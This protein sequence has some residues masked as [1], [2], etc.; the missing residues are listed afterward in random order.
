MPP[1][2]PAQSS[3]DRAKAEAVVRQLWIAYNN[4]GLYGDAHPLTKRAVN[5]CLEALN[6]ALE[7]I[8]MVTLHLEQDFIAC[9]EWRIEKR[10]YGPRL[11]ARLKDAKIQSLSF[12]RDLDPVDFIALLEVLSNG[13]DYPLVDDLVDELAERKAKGFRFNYVTYQKVTM[14]ESIIQR[15]LHRFAEL[16]S[17]NAG[18]AESPAADMLGAPAHVGRQSPSLILS[19]L[20]AIRR[21]VDQESGGQLPPAEEIVNSLTALRTSVIQD[22]RNQAAN[23]VT[24]EVDEEVFSEIEQLTVEV[25]LRIV[26]EEYR[27]ENLSV[28][29]LAMLIQRLLPDV[30]ELRRMLPHLKRT[31]LE[32]GMSLEDYLLLVREL[33]R[34]LQDSGIVD[35]LVETGKELGVS[36]DEIIGS[37]RSDPRTAV[38]LMLLAAEI[39]SSGFQDEGAFAA[40]IQDYIEQISAALGDRDSRRSVG[41]DDLSTTRALAALEREFSTQLAN[42]GASAPVRESISEALTQNGV[43]A[44]RSRP[45]DSA[46]SAR[47]ADSSS[48]AHPASA[49]DSQTADA[50]IDSLRSRGFEDSRISGYREFLEELHATIGGD[51]SLLAPLFDDYLSAVQAGPVQTS[52]DDISERQA[53]DAAM[54]KIEEALA[55]LQARHGLPREKISDISNAVTYHIQSLASQAS[56]IDRKTAPPL[57]ELLARK[58]YSPADIERF[59]A[60][61]EEMRQLLGDDLEDTRTV[62]SGFINQLEEI[63]NTPGRG[64]VAESGNR[65]VDEALARL[66]QDFLA[67]LG[68]AGM[69]EEQI[70]A[71]GRALARKLAELIA[72]PRDAEHPR[73]ESSL[74]AMLKARGYPEKELARF[75]ALSEEMSRELGPA[76]E[77]TREILAEFIAHSNHIPARHEGNIEPSNAATVDAILVRL[78]DEFM[79]FLQRRGVSQQRLSVIGKQLSARLAHL[80]VHSADQDQRHASPENK[81][82]S[83]SKRSR[84][85]TTPALMRPK[86]TRLFLEREIARCA[87]YGCAFSCLSYSVTAIHTPDGSRSPAEYELIPLLNAVTEQLAPSLRTPDIIGAVGSAAKNHILVVLPMTGKEGADIVRRRQIDALG[88]MSVGLDNQRASVSVITS[89]ETFEGAKPIQV[90]SFLRRVKSTH[91]KACEEQGNR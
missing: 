69:P 36:I 41:D 3:I 84:P 27:A 48:V 81:P 25:I 20:R 10:A 30:R 22:L 32:E 90:S 67:Y 61:A 52:R 82:S 71:I 87:R 1:D 91:A 50:I 9:E 13:A 89:A 39:K 24:G 75:L 46:E 79:A 37:L 60:L 85:R 29:Q 11:I 38:S 66:E 83:P 80:L 77:E 47:L 63:P 31:L 28:K 7:E 15:D 26:K 72:I 16:L 68:R 45:A 62:L 17:Q 54:A 70:S 40:S 49:A 43:F 64:A 21:A 18:P 2:K 88:A 35:A 14:D 6:A 34:E 51:L 42:R 23:G 19:H 44:L 73:D 53:L 58:G 33:D 4:I 5:D 57:P 74:S 65:A 76:L 59:G 8:A 78:E 56:A 12:Y 86:D 55:E